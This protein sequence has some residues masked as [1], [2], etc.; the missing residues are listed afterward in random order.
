[1]WEGR[2]EGRRARKGK[3]RVAEEVGK[4]RVREEEGRKRRE[5][6]RYKLKDPEEYDACVEG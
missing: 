4:P 1:M 5:L 2:Q 3:R 6:K